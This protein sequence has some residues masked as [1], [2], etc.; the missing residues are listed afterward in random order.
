MPNRTLRRPATF[1]GALLIVLLAACEPGPGTDSRVA[2]VNGKPVTQKVFDAYVA[3]R[4]G[5]S[6]QISEADRRDLL[7]QVISIELLM[8]DALAQGLD[9]EARTAGELAVQRA[10]LLA[11]A[12]IR[13]HLDA[14][15]VTDAAVKAE[16]DRK[17]KELAQVEYKARHILV[18][19]E[20]EAKEIIGQLE[21]GGRFDRLARARSTDEGTAQQG[22]DL[23]WF[24]PRM[25]VKPFADAVAALG[26]GG[27]TKS[28]V[29][30]QFG[31]H[32]IQV[33]G[34]REMPPPPFEQVRD[35]IKGELQNQ[36]VEAYINGL[37]GAA[38]I[39]TLDGAE[40]D[41]A[42]APEAADGAPAPVEG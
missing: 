33:E 31:W 29:Q 30:S 5:G 34:R 37:R 3:R 23:G 40:E 15:P 14:N 27:L 19:S 42:A 20:A 1:P 4:S 6:G 36:A 13:A 9:R 18:P 38:K 22:G 28:P 17:A 10:T 25:M 16:Y 32:V 35:R 2:V 11:N 24:V 12:A 7:N 21:R 41:P 8:Q 26:D 39:E